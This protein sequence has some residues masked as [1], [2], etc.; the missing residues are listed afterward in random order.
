M[1][2]VYGIKCCEAQLSNYYGSGLINSVGDIERDAL[3]IYYVLKYISRDEG[4]TYIMRP[5]LE[6]EAVRAYQYFR[7]GGTGSP[8]GKSS[9]SS[10][11]RRR[12]M[13]STQ[14]FKRSSAEWGRALEFLHEKHVVVIETA[15]TCPLERVY[16]RSLWEAERN[17][18][19]TFRRL[20]CKQQLSPWT[21]SI[22]TDK[23]V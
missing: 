8:R 14:Q 23:Y 3:H 22:D 6:L 12:P 15:G 20:Q 19:S 16:L 7:S 9:N 21:F 1:K 17:I 2:A 11:P 13:M 4:H 10:S 5:R 18:A